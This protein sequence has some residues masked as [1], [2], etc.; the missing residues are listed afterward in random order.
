[1]HTPF[2][3]ISEPFGRSCP[4]N[5]QLRCSSLSMTPVPPLFESD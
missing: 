4:L 1:M 2:M 3:H 5:V